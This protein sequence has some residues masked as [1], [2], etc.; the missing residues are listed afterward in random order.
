MQDSKFLRPLLLGKVK[1]SSGTDQYANELFDITVKEAM[2]KNWLEGPFDVADIDNMFDC[3]LPVRRFAVFQRGK[4]RPIDDMKENK[5]N[6]SFSCG[7]KIDLQA[8]D[9]LV[10]SLQVITRF[11]LHGGELDLC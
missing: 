8:L 6:Q 5:L 2:D 4:V 11:C 1:S 7:E 10:W 9:H 3:W